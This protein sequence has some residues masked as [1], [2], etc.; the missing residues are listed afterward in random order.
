MSRNTRRCQRLQMLKEL[1]PRPHCGADQLVA[2]I[3][4]FQQRV[5]AEG[6]HVHRHQQAGQMLF[7]VAEIMFRSK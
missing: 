6:Q 3:G 1:P 5:Q 4:Q 7:A 2:F